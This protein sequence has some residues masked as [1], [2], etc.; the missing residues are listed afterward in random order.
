MCHHMESWINTKV[1]FLKLQMLNI[2][3]GKNILFYFFILKV[4]MV[5]KRR[6]RQVS[7]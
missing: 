2:L 6:A 3:M 4:K 1:V 7:K 5:D